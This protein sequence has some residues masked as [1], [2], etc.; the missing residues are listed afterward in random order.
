MRP[1]LLKTI[2]VKMDLVVIALNVIGNYLG[3]GE[4]NITKS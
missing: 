4:R 3:F 2:K 1:S